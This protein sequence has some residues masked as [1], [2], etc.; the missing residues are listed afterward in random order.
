MK[1]VIEDRIFDAID[2]LYIG[3]VVAKGFDNSKEY[4]E[5]EEK[6][7]EALKVAEE[8][9]RD[10]KVKEDEA[11]V[12]YREAF[13]KLGINPN[14]FQCSVEAMFGR[15]SKGKGIPSINPLVNINNSISL[16]NT[17]PMGTHDLSEVDDSIEMRL[18]R[19]GDTF[20]PMGSDVV[21]SPDA[22]EV[23]YAVGNEVRTRRWTQRQSEKGKIDKDTN[24][25]FFPID[26]FKGINDV[27]VDKVVKELSEV[28][29]GY[30]CEVY[31]GVVDKDN[32]VFEW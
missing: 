16:F 11:V 2:N 21:E 15:I 25:V 12:P 31:S 17:L 8:R 4:P 10:V 3:V 6:L 20:I 26:G 14:K 27:A 13:R 9:F 23:V 30:G 7:N 29:K 1:F 18:S 28:M 19:E 5:V 32:K 24:Y 22:D